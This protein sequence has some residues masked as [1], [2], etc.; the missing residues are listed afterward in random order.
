[1]PKSENFDQNI[2]Q[3]IGVEK[4]QFYKDAAVYLLASWKRLS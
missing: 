2:K 3:T 4:S 1:V